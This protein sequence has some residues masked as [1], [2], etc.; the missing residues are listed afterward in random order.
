LEKQANDDY[1]RSLN[2]FEQ[3]YEREENNVMGHFHN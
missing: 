1:L 3:R 2:E